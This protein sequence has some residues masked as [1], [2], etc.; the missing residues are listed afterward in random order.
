MRDRLFTNE[1]LAKLGIG[2]DLLHVFCRA[3]IENSDHLFFKVL[4][5][6]KDMEEHYKFVLSGIPHYLSCEALES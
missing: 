5:C 2:N 3:G 1:R 6:S 4:L